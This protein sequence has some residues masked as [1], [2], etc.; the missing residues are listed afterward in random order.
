MQRIFIEKGGLTMGRS[1]CSPNN[2]ASKRSR[3]VPFHAY[4]FPSSSCCTSKDAV[5]TKVFVEFG[6]KLKWVCCSAKRRER[7]KRNKIHRCFIERRSDVNYHAIDLQ[8]HIQK[9]L[10]TLH[11]DLLDDASTC[12]FSFHKR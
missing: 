11:V 6:A 5:S 1:D 3:C 10:M 9:V 7:L 8:R 12:L 2:V 4:T